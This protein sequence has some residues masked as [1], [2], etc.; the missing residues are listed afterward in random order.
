VIAFMSDV[1]NG[2]DGAGVEP[3]W[4]QGR[5][6]GDKPSPTETSGW[7][8][9][10]SGLDWLLYGAVAT[11]S[12]AIGLVNAL[13]AA[14]DT[15]WRGGDYNLRTPLLTEMSSIA[16]IILVAP[17]LFVAVRRL[18]QTSSWA[19]RAGVAALAIIA[20]SALHIVVMVAIRKVVMTLIGGAYEFGFSITAL[21]YEFRKDAVTCLLIGGALWLIKGYRE[22]QRTPN[23]PVEAKETA[24]PQTLWL[25]D[26][27]SR[28]RI[29][30][31]DI[32][33]ISSA[34]NYV[35]YSLADGT[36]HLIRG[37]LSAAE[38]ELGRF[39]L[40]RVHRTRL[41]N[42][43]RVTAIDVKPSGDFELTFDT[44]KT[45]Q[46]SRRYRS[47]VASLQG[48]GAAAEASL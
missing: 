16:A 33:W 46:G 34:G 32:L 15:A 10:I 9:W 14:Q 37:T 28:I 22:A 35:E 36:H 26:G 11:V 13:S 5:L 23:R 4:D 18:R 44:G 21:M 25:R 39:K 8:P 41:A 27:T 43:D 17:V 20:F 19:R 3:V 2:H 12:L 48:S 31:G 6:V 29:D 40:A 42:L 24:A 47:A 30:P 45:I 38:A 1:K 7:V